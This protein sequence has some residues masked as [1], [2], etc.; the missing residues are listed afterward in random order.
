MKANQ[1]TPA[2]LEF[3]SE[4][5]KECGLSDTAAMFNF[6][7]GKEKTVGQIRSCLKNHGFTCGRA[8]GELNKGKLLSYTDAQKAWIEREY[9]NHSLSELVL[10]FNT[11]FQDTKTEGQ[12]RGFTRNHKIKS[13]RTGRFEAGSDSWNAGKKGWSAGGDSIKTRFKKGDTP[14][15]HR[16]VGSERVSVDGYIEIKVAEPA[17]WDLK[18]RVVWE[19][20]HGPIPPSHV[21]WF[22]D[23]NPLNCAPDNLML[24]TR[25]HHAVVSKLGLHH[26]TGELKETTKLIADVAMARTAGRKKL[27]NNRRPKTPKEGL[28]DGKSD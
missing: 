15:N 7:F 13:G 24:V 11:V 27:Q 2:Q 16:P 5:Y 6:T 18:H 26:A 22:I 9:P 19:Q 1:Y 23:N 10:L 14:A 8:K 17:S 4:T 20:E 21:I 25:A 12:I 3:I 28:S